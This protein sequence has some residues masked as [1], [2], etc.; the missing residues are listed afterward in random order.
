MASK[1]LTT[2]PSLKCS[3]IGRLVII[4][5]LKVLDGLGSSSLRFLNYLLIEYMLLTLA[6]MKNWA[7]LLT[8]K[9]QIIWLK[10]LPPKRVLPFGCKENLWEMGDTGPCGPCSKIHF[11]RIG[12]RD[13]AELVNN[14]DPTLIEIWNIVFIQVRF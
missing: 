5:K 14:D 9:L 3:V 11:D 13:A 4:S 10:Y 1:T 2:T 12:G 6:V 7:F 8:T